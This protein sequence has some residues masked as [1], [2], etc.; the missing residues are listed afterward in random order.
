MSR[1]QIKKSFE[2][3]SEDQAGP[4][5]EST[6]ILLFLPPIVWQVC[7][8]PRYGQGKWVGS[9]LDQHSSWGG[10]G[11][12]SLH[13]MGWQG[14]PGFLG[15]RHLSCE[16]GLYLLVGVHN[17]HYC[18]GRTEGKF[19]SPR[20][21]HYSHRCFC[22]RMCAFFSPHWPVFRHQQI[23]VQFSSV[24]IPSV[25][26]KGQNPQVKDSGPWLPPLEVSVAKSQTVT[27]TSGQ[28]ALIWG[29]YLQSFPQVW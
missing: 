28:K 5:L 16:S 13:P 12:A 20:P 3:F 25:W 10:V 15:S 24:L 19:C 26:H 9:P 1:N 27:C 2:S 29:S 18:L 22:N 17:V 14:N 7:S 21:T 11:L 4:F 6:S 8:W 23:V